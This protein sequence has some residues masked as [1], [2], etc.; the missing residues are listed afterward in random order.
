[1]RI[2]IIGKNIAQKP[3]SVNAILTPFSNILFTGY[4]LFPSF[5]ILL[6][7]VQAGYLF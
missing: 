1:M 6:S 5:L 2:N 7:P 3:K 4:Y